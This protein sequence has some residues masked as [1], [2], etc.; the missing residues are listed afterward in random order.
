MSTFTKVLIGDTIMFS[1]VNSG[2]N[3]SP[4]FTAHDG[5]EALVESG[6]FTSSGNG[7]YYYDYTVTSS[8]FFRLRGKGIVNS[9]DYIRQ[10][11]VK[12]VLGGVD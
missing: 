4:E 5:E 6:T 12:G 8:G 3:M 7:H 11:I 2:V 9:R 10:E 1:W